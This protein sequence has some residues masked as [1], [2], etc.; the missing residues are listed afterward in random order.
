[1]DVNRIPDELSRAVYQ[2]LIKSRE[3]DTFVLQMIWQRL[4]LQTKEIL[5]C[6]KTWYFGE[7]GVEPGWCVPALVVLFEN[8][9]LLAKE[10]F[11]ANLIDLAEQ[12][13]SVCKCDR[14]HV[15]GCDTG[16][17]LWFDYHTSTWVRASM[18]L[19][20]DWHREGSRDADG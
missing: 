17:R 19:P 15:I 14:V 6:S 11:G 5:E 4:A 16:L 18:T 20:A 13:Q 12:C 3:F 10:Q 1:M 8:A 2:R 9:A 7:I